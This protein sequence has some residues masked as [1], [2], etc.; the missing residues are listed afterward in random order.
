MVVKRAI[1]AAKKEYYRS[2]ITS[3]TTSKALYQLT[4]TLSGK[5][6]ATSLPEHIL[7]QQIPDHFCAY[8]HDKVSRMRKELDNCVELLSFDIFQGE[9]LHHFHA[10]DSTTV[11]TIVMKSAPKSCSLE[12]IPSDLLEQHID[13]IID[14]MTNLINASLR[15]G[16]VPP[17]FKTAAITP[18]IKKPSLDPNYLKNFRPVSN[19]PFI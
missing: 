10:V 4:N 3:C 8:F 14:V 5:E 13:D 1:D 2:M 12:P 19:L 17:A 7:K 6:K 9:K 16:V 15:D 11:K 18:L